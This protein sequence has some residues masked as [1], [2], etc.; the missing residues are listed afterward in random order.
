MTTQ[1]AAGDAPSKHWGKNRIQTLIS[2]GETASATELSVKFNLICPLTA[3]IA[4]DESEKVA[5]AS[6]ALTQPVLE[7]ES[8]GDAMHFCFSTAPQSVRVSTPMARFMRAGGGI[9]FLSAPGGISKGMS[10]SKSSDLTS[11]LCEELGSRRDPEDVLRAILANAGGGAG[12]QQPPKAPDWVERLR[13]FDQFFKQIAVESGLQ[14]M[15]PAFLTILKWVCSEE[16]HRTARSELFAR[17]LLDLWQMALKQGI[18]IAQ[19]CRKLSSL[20]RKGVKTSESPI[21]LKIFG[22]G[23]WRTEANVLQLID[24]EFKGTVDPAVVMPFFKI[25]NEMRQ[26]I[27]DF[28]RQ[29]CKN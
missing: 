27:E 8:F 25:Q 4:W 14:V 1:P 29:H 21:T 13:A 26:G 7:V 6:H 11:G 24:T 19:L 17:L 10:G 12:N 16:K 2:A 23:Q 5:V 20:E 3:F 28:A 15:E 22:L 9:S 18:A